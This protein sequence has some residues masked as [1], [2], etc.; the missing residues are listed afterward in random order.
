MMLNVYT[1]PPPP[2]HTHSNAQR[3]AIFS[4]KGYFWLYVMGR[5]PEK[6]PGKCGILVANTRDRR[7]R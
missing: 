2:T 4:G 7:F 6:N 3:A 5:F 1:T